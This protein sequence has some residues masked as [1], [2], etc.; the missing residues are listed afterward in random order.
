M[1]R[2]TFLIEATNERI[3]CLLNPASLVQQ[4]RAGVYS[5]GPA[6]LP[7][8]AEG[9]SDDPLVAA[10]GG[11]TELTLDLLFDITLAGSSIGGDD[12]RQLTGP[13]WQL[14]ENAREADG[15]RRLPVVR[16]IWGKA[17]N[18]RGVITAIAERLE[19]FTAE[20][21]PQRSWLRLRLRRIDDPPPPLPPSPPS[22]AALA[23]L[24]DV[25]LEALESAAIPVIESAGGPITPAS[26]PEGDE[27]VAL[28]AGTRL[29][30]LAAVVYGDPAYWRL[31]AAVNGIIDPLRVAPGTPLRL[32]PLDLLLSLKE[33]R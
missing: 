5:R 9:L 6:G 25:P 7:V 2:V 28:A 33:D 12:V 19:R 24:A 20:G 14:S 18:V 30:L 1:E 17:W 8:T 10:G 3:G 27:R 21:A 23:A 4:R 29:D 22:P 26:P 32:P 31:I 11:V 16:F 15:S 13:L